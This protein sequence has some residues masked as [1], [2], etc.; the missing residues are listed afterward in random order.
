MLPEKNRLRKQKDFDSVHQ[1]GRGVSGPL[2]NLQFAPNMG[3]YTRLAFVV[4]KKTAH[5][6]V[7][8]NRIK[9]LFRAAAAR[10]VNLL[11]PGLDVVIIIK[12]AKSDI[13]EVNEE[14]TKSFKKAD[15]YRSGATND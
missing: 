14:L 5:D 12:R 7:A 9:R 4:S 11:K 8:R 3:A 13:S 10:Q 2:F 15:L 6:A 1:R